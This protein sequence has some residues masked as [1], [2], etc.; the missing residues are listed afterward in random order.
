MNRSKMMME[1]MTADAVEFIISIS[2]FDFAF[3]SKASVHIIVCLGSTHTQVRRPRLSAAPSFYVV[4]ILHRQH[5]LYLMQK[6]YQ[7]LN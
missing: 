4:Q 7:P 5:L 3:A 6:V 2:I 1:Q